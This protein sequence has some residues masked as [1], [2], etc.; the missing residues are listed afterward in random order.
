MNLASLTPEEQSL[1]RTEVCPEASD[2]HINY[3]LRVCAAR[4]VDPFS[5]LMYLMVR[6]SKGKKKAAV[7]FTIDGARATAARNDAY[8]GSDEPEFD[9]EDGPYPK[10]AKC[11]VYRMVKNIRCAFTAKVRWSEFKPEAPSDYQWKAKPYHM[12]SKVAEQQALRKAFPEDI[13]DTSESHDDDEGNEKAQD[14]ATAEE[15]LKSGPPASWRKALAAFSSFNVDEKAML[16]KVGRSATK[17]VTE[18]DMSTLFAWYEEL[19]RDD[20]PPPE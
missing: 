1:L 13:F 8:A 20:I 15:K 10:W 2:A 3:Y 14:A 19:T 16:A 18:D 4:N 7:A 17:D 6:V 5:G 9:S 11:T 12:L